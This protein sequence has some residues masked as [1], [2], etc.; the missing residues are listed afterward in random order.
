[1]DTC[2]Y[3]MCNEAAIRTNVPGKKK[4]QCYLKFFVS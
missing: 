3:F 2:V 4:L 1:M